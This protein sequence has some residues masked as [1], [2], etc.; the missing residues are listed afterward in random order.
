MKTTKETLENLRQ[1][2]RAEKLSEKEVKQN[3]IE[4]FDHWFDEALKSGI[5]EPNAMTLA[6]ASHDGKPSARIVLLKGFNKDGFVFYTNYL[7]RKGK[8]LAKNPVVAAVFHWGELERQVRIEGTIE[9][10]SKEESEKYFNSRPKESQIGALASPQ[11]QVIEGRG[12]LEKNW[13]ELE[14]KYKDQH[15]PKPSFW[16][17]YIIKPQVIEFWQGRPSRLHDRIVYRKADKTNWK[18]VRLAP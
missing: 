7:S 11:S 13:A 15:I 5:Y 10:V 14:E 12:S 3:P 9:K 17:G 16:G 6:T 2:Y 4:Q 18:I 8:E 1:D